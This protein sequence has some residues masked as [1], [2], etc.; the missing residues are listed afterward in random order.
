MHYRLSPSDLTFLYEG[1]KHCFVLKVKHGVAQPSIPL[2]AIF[3]TITLLQKELYSGKRT[4]SICA[5]PP[6]GVV[7]YGEQQVRSRPI[8]FPGLENGC[9][10][11][12]RFDI[13]AELDDRSYGVFDFKTGKPTDEKAGMYGR[14]LHAYALALE[15][16]AEGALALKPVTSLGLLYFTPDRCTQAAP[17]RQVLE[18][19]M[20]WQAVRLD[21][22]PFVAFLEGVVRLLDGP[23]PPMEP[24]QCDWCA[25]RRR[26]NG[27]AALGAA[28]RMAEAGPG[29]PACPTCNG[30]MRR[31][32]GKFGEFWSCMNY[33]ACKG[34]RNVVGSS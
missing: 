26:T 27:D 6:P 30:P 34:T 7:R 1:C 5:G 2:P 11:S 24:A 8:T 17:P 31:R 9:Y 13:V 20:R 28:G 33:P 16:P 15:Q 21:D 18:G 25:Y 3:N 22:G 4:E 19:E 32:S 23:M 12:G 29:A 10:L 14:Q